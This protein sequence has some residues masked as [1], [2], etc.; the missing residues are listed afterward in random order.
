M[1]TI[2]IL[3]QATKRLGH[4]TNTNKPTDAVL[5]R[6]GPSQKY[7]QLAKYNQV[8]SNVDVG[9]VDLSKMVRYT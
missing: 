4:E 2:Q 8:R 7:P 1:K 5:K 6:R 3:P 9:E